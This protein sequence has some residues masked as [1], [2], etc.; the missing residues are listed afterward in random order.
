MRRESPEIPAHERTAATEFRIGGKTMNV[1]RR[2]SLVLGRA[3]KV[4]TKSGLALLVVTLLLGS[5]VFAP[6]V[7]AQ[8]GSFGN[9]PAGTYHFSS[10]GVDF[11][12]FTSNMQIFFNLTASTDVRRPEGA[13]QTTTSQAE[14]FLSLFDYSSV[15]FTSVCLFLDKPS[16]F[17]IDSGLT[18]ATL[19]TTLTP[20]TPVCPGSSP[21]TNSIAISGSW[22]GAGPV[23]TTSDES[24]YQCGK[25]R[26]DSVGRNLFNSGSAN[27]TVTIAGASTTFSSSQIGLNSNDLK[28][29]AEGVAGPGCGPA[30]AGIGRVAAGDYHS[31]GLNTSAFFGMPPGP[32]DQ[33]SLNENNQ[34]SRPEGGSRTSS[35]EFDLNVSLF[36]GGFNGFGCWIISPADVTSTGLTSATINTTITATTPNCT[37]TFPGFGINYP[38]TVNAVWTGSGP[39][40]KVRDQNTYKCLGYTETTESS[41]QSNAAGSIATLTTPDSLGNPTTISLS[42]GQGSLVNID[43][44]IQAEGVDQQACMTRA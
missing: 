32:T 19:S 6:T 4:K 23:S 31:F 8:K 39:L 28:V 14:V 40:V 33:I 11:Q 44:R 34:S 21:L 27:L 25:Y 18:T 35:Q 7:A 9:L 1:L 24:S 17:T 20:T 10:S 5:V 13:P 30:G 22:T 37:N 15:T 3:G 29:D 41:V 43:Q 16:D 38:L 26:S 42:G 36:G 2:A 12:A